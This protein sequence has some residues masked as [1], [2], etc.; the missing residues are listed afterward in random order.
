[1]RITLIDKTGLGLPPS[2]TLARSPWTRANDNVRC[3]TAPA[4]SPHHRSQDRPEACVAIP[5]LVTL[6]YWQPHLEKLT[7][8]II[9]TA[10]IHPLPG[11]R[12]P[13]RARMYGA[14][15]CLRLAFFFLKA[16][17][18]SVFSFHLSRKGGEYDVLLMD[19]V[20]FQ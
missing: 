9:H 8:H 11:D 7:V 19:V 16:S 18:L 13:R 4:P 6:H 15:Y 3:V 1:M 14:F 17:H 12:I 5:R 10:K 2:L 20:I